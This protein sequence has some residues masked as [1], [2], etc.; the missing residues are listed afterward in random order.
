MWAHLCRHTS[1][2]PGP[3]VLSAPECALGGSGPSW[4]WSTHCSQRCGMKAYLL[5]IG[6]CLDETP[7]AWQHQHTH[8]TF[9]IQQA[10]CGTPSKSLVESLV[11]TQMRCLFTS[12]PSLQHTA[13]GYSKLYMHMHLQPIECNRRPV[14]HAHQACWAWLIQAML[15]SCAVC[16]EWAQNTDMCCGACQG[17]RAANGS[18][19]SPALGVG[20]DI[21]YTSM[22]RN[23][24]H[25]HDQHP[26]A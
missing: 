1:G 5:Q 2:P 25:S 19:I 3:Q 12:E 24:R 18:C 7:P 17:T 23:P 15:T 9:H 20:R 16:I 6:A 11:G 13:L 4:A 21:A 14:C 26:T 10:A 22:A 8:C